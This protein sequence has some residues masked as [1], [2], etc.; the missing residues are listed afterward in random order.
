MWAI[1][2]RSGQTLSLIGLALLVTTCDDYATETAD[3]EETLAPPVAMQSVRSA[4]SCRAN[5]RSATLDCERPQGVGQSFGPSFLI[6]GGQ[7][8]FVQLASANPDYDGTTEVFSADVTVQNLIAQPIGSSDGVNVTGV[9]VFFHTGPTVTQW[10]GP[11]APT[12]TVANADG[13]ATFTATD[14]LYHLYDEVLLPGEVSA[15]KTW[16]WDVPPEAT[17]FVFEV[18]VEGPVYFP[19]G[20]I[21]VAPYPTAVGVGSTVPLTA[22]IKDVIG[23]TVT[24]TVNWSSSAD[25]VATVNA[26]GT[27]SGVAPGVADIVASVQGKP[28]GWSRVTVIGS[29]YNVEL[30]TWNVPPTPPSAS[31]VAAFANAKARWEAVIT[32]DVQEIAVNYT[33]GIFSTCPRIYE[34]IDDLLIFV[35]VD[36]IDGPYNIVGQAGPCLLRSGGTDPGTALAG[37]MTFDIADLEIMADDGILEDVILHEMGHVLGIG[38][39]WGSL[40][41]PSNCTSGTVDPYFNG[42][43]AVAAFDAAGGTAYTGGNKVPVEDTGGQGTV[44]SHWRDTVHDNE[45]MT[46]WVNLGANPL[47]AITIQSL[48]DMG[49]SVDLTAADAYTLPA[50]LAPAVRRGGIQLKNDVLLGPIYTV[51]PQ[52]TITRL[53]GR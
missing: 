29:G 1:T 18:F 11:T 43:L 32:N 19:S 53:P 26:A 44:C 12:V 13:F 47:S 31:I 40:L 5:V 39:L 20:W 8:E 21:E 50:P 25:T 52:G 7:G 45:L 41:A 51:D 27:V 16:E 3:Q 49:Y 14:Q 22:T 46:G 42:P 48:A 15:S 23:R 30:R 37:S 33:P 36:S 4:L 10:T 9:R 35:S 6:V 28:D 24:G 2:S 34:V 38:V 17:E